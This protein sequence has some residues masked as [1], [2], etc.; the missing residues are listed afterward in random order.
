M[1]GE[2]A[3]TVSYEVIRKRV[4]RGTAL[5]DE[6]SPGWWRWLPPES[7]DMAYGNHCVL[8]SVNPDVGYYGMLDE[9]EIS[10]SGSDEPGTVVWYGF[11]IACDE[12]TADSCET[13]NRLTDTWRGLVGARQSAAGLG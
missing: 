8:G 10:D 5:L 7:I 12:Y 2:S 1:G 9:L 6:R 13:Y 11:D 3:M 4:A